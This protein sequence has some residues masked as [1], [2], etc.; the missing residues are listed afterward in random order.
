VADKQAYETKQIKTLF[1]SKE[2]K[3]DIEAVVKSSQVEFD[4]LAA[5]LQATIKPVDS[6]LKVEA[7]R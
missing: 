5:A 4:R 7:V 2:A 6:V 1:R 3:A